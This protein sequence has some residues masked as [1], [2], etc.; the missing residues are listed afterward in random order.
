M[1]LTNQYIKI[2]RSFLLF[3]IKYSLNAGLINIILSFKYF[4]VREISKKNRGSISHECDK[5]Q[6]YLQIDN[7]QLYLSM[8]CFFRK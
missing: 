8:W 3:P 1:P 6:K 7:E 4:L 2:L 5:F